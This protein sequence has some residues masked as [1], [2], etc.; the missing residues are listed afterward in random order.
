MDSL[1]E[2]IHEQARVISLIAVAVGIYFFL[3]FTGA[4]FSKEDLRFYII[5]WLVLFFILA[6]NDIAFNTEQSR[7]LLEIIHR[8]MVNKGR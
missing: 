7:K 3:V 8:N 4:E 5:F 2:W 1:L 6:I